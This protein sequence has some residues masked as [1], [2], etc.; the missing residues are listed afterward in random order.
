MFRPQSEGGEEMGLW[1]R[2]EA[3]AGHA[4]EWKVKKTLFSGASE[5]QRIEVLELEEFGVALVLDGI[6][7][8]TS[9]DEFIYHEMLAHV[10]LA[11]HPNPRSVLI[12]GGGDGGLARE[13]LR[14]PAVEEVVLVEIDR[15]VVEVAKTYLPGHTTALADPRLVIHYGDGARF[16]RAGSQRARFDLIL[17]DSTDPEGSGPGAWLYSTEFHRDVRQS[18]KADGIFVQ[19][20]GAP[21]YNP[22]VFAGVA[23]EMRELFSWAGVYWTVVPTYPGGLFTFTAG[24]KGPDVSEPRHRAPEPTRWYRPEMHRQSFVLPWHFADRLPEDMRRHGQEARRS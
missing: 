14:W 10:P 5:Y 24:S 16:L 3:S 19:Q 12:I 13:V 20:T 8:T 1:F 6:M 22:E 9:G 23:G 21:F 4:L 17:V 2:E 11:A 15:M 7:Q 18:L